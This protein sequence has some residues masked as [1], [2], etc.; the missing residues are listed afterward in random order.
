MSK[1]ELLKKIE[2]LESAVILSG[3][4][5]YGGTYEEGREY[6]EGLYKGEYDE[7]MAKEM[8]RCKK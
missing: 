3:Y 1:D 4:H 7:E 8:E 5:E 2:R 6:I